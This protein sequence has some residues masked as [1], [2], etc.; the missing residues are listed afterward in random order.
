MDSLSALVMTASPSGVFSLLPGITPLWCLSIFADD[1][2]L[3]VM[4][5]VQDLNLSALLCTSSG[6]ALACK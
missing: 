1:I 3:F 4:T 5:S 2:V 6:M